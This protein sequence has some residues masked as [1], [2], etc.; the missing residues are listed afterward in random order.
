[1]I[2]IDT[3]KNILENIP[4]LK[5]AYLFGSQAKKSAIETSD[6]DIA[7]YI[8]EK[9]N[10]FDTKLKVHHLLEISLNKEIDIIVLNNVKN[11]H[12]LQDIFDNNIVLKDSKNDKRVMFEL[13]KQ[14]EIIDYFEFKRMLDVA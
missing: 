6:I 4:E 9:Y 11:F 1:M 12:L 2:K 5:F 7:I 10:H 14:H 8:D 13:S 3:I